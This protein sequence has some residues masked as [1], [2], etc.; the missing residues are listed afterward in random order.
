MSNK[1]GIVRNRDEM[2]DALK[3]IN[4]IIQHYPDDQTDYNGKKYMNSQ[5]SAVLSASRPWKGRR[6]AAVM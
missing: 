4:E 1:V 2:A 3:R 5:Q 6:A